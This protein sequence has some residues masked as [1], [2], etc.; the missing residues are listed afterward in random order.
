MVWFD[1]LL[2][3]RWTVTGSNS[4]PIDLLF[5]QD[6]RPPEE[7]NVSHLPGV[8]RVDPDAQHLLESLHIPPNSRGALPHPRGGSLVPRPLVFS[9]VAWVQGYW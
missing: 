6:T 4:F 9:S 3:G 1:G 5:V 8:V 7:Y 2:H